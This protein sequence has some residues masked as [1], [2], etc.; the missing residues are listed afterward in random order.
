MPEIR[1][2]FQWPVGRIVNAWPGANMAEE[3]FNLAPASFRCVL[4]SLNRRAFEIFEMAQPF[5][6]V[7]VEYAHPIGRIAAQ[8][9]KD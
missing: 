6:P 4:L 5:G 2:W 8:F 7:G 3:G 9:S 1:R